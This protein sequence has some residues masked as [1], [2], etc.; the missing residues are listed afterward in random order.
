MTYQDNSW[1]TWQEMKGTHSLNLLL[2][3]IALHVLLLLC[4]TQDCLQSYA[5]TALRLVNKYSHTEG[6]FIITQNIQFLAGC[7]CNIYLCTS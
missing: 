3:S 4:H 7:N 5:Y 2:C 1:R 6:Q